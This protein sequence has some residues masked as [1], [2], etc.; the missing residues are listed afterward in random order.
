[1]KPVYKNPEA[2]NQFIASNTSGS[3]KGIYPV[4]VRDTTIK[5]RLKPDVS[6]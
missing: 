4:H 2:V 3:N 6:R 1:M 5:A